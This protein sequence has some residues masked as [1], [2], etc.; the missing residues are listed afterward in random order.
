LW[1][2]QRGSVL[3]KLRGRRRRD[4]EPSLGKRGQRRRVEQLLGKL[5]QQGRVEQLLGELGLLEQLLGELERLEQLLGELGLLE[6]LLGRRFL[7]SGLSAVS[8]LP[9]EQH[10]L[11]LR[12]RGD[13]LHR[14]AQ[15]HRLQVPDWIRP[16]PRLH[17]A[18]WRLVLLPV[19]GRY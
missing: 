13:R 17:G 7:Q 15:D 19:R 1:S 2:E 11:W 8:D 18:G 10:L 3:R 5:K 14:P 12:K 9:P 6:Q 4:V 16:R